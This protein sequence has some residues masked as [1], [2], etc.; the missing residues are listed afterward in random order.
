[1]KGRGILSGIFFLL[2]C[3]ACS[4]EIPVLGSIPSF[5]LIDQQKRKVSLEDLKGKV[6]V[7]NFVFTSCAGTCPLLTKRMTLVQ[8][9]L[10][11][12]QAE[13]RDLPVRIVSFSVDPERDTP[14]K[15]ADYAKRYGAKA[16][17]WYFLTGPVEQVTDTVVNGFKMAM[18]KVPM[19]SSA[20]QDKGEVFDVV[21]GER[22]V[23][24][25]AEG[26]IRGYYDSQDGREIRKLLHDLKTLLR[27][28]KG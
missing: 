16:E 18:G 22:F 26:R 10:N 28:S 13:R 1:M 6:W 7:A 27:E 25:D 14:E 11:E 4:R 17:L 23:L 24:I 8:D 3:A 15:L 21:H 5:Q 12:M 19:G 2:W 9:R 20:P